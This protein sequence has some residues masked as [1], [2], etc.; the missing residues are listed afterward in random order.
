[1]R[2]TN[3]SFFPEIT[4]RLCGIEGHYQT[5]CPVARNDTGEGLTPTPNH[6][7]GSGAATASSATTEE[8]VSRHCG[9]VL[10]QHNEAHIHPCWV[11]LES[12]SANHIFCNEK[13]LTNIEP[14]TDGECLRMHSSGGHLDTQQKGKFGDF[15]VWYDPKSLANILSLALVTEKYRVTLDSESENAFIVHVSA[16]H[17]IKFVRGPCD[18]YYFDANNIDLSKLKLAFSFLNTVDEN[19]K[20]YKKREVRKATDAIVLNRRTNHIAKD[21]FIRPC[22]QSRAEPGI[23]SPKGS[24]TPKSC[25]SPSRC[26]KTFRMLSYVLISIM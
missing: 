16:G 1:M 6:R 13:L 9:L 5:H 26:I 10:S 20:L 14:T 24:L 3:N 4:C 23:R 8:E 19:K 11:L 25:R 22:R 18:L 12:K 17:E 15:E 7:S 21:K 2:A